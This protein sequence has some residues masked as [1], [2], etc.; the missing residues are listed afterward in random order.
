M[1]KVSTLYCII[2]F[3]ALF[4][5]HSVCQ[6]KIHRNLDVEDGLVQSQVF[7]ILEAQDGYLWVGTADGLSRW[8]GVNFV[9]F[10]ADD[11]VIGDPFYAIHESSD[12]TLYFGRRNGVS[13]YKNG[14]LAALDVD[15]FSEYTITAITESEDG[16]LYF[17]TG[18]YGVIE[19]KNGQNTVLNEQ[20]GLAHNQ[21]NSLHI[22]KDGRLYLGTAGGL[23][24]YSERK[25]TNVS[26]EK[27]LGSNL[28]LSVF[29]GRNEKSYIA[30]LQGLGVYHNNSLEKV[31]AFGNSGLG[32]INTVYEATDGTLYAGTG[33]SGVECVREGKFETITDEHGLGDNWITCIYE[34]KDGTI[35]FG[36]R[37]GLSIYQNGKFET[38]NRDGLTQNSVQTIY[39]DHSARMYFSGFADG[40]TIY[41]DGKYE[42]LTQRDG[43]AHDWVVSMSEGKDKTMYFGTD[44]SGVSVY[45][46]GKFNTLNQGNGLPRN[47]VSSMFTGSD[48]TIYF[49]FWNG[50]VGIY[51]EGEFVQVW[52]E[53]SGLPGSNI[54]AFHESQSETL[55]IGTRGNGV[56]LYRDGRQEKAIST[57]NGLASNIVYAIHEAKDGTFYFGTHRGLSILKAGQFKTFSMLNGLTSN[58]IY[59][60]LEGDSSQIYLVTDVGINIVDFSSESPFVRTLRYR[61]GLASDECKEKLYL[62]DSKGNFWFGTVK[63]ITKYDPARDLPN[64][65][66]PKLHLSRVSLLGQDVLAADKSVFEHDQ[67]Y[68]KYD[69]IGINLSAPEKVVYRYRLSGV[70]E[71]WVETAQRSVQ[72]T[73]LDDGSY[74]F[75]VKARNEWGVWSEPE[76][77]NFEILPP[78]WER[79]WF[80][81][82]AGLLFFGTIAY[83][84]M[85]HVRQ[86]L[87]TE[88]L[89]TKIAADLHDSIGSGLAEITILSEICIKSLAQNARRQAEQ[90]L[91]TIGK[92]S[93]SLVT[94]MS[95]I[96]W[97]V[98]PQ[99]DSLY[100]LL[101]R[102]KG[103]YE[104]LLRHKGIV[105]KMPNVKSMEKIHLPMEHRHQLYLLF[106][107]GVTNCLKHSDCTELILDTEVSSRELKMALK[108]NGKGFDV[109]QILSKKN[110]GE[111][112]VNMRRRAE[113]M[114]GALHLQSSLGKG[115]KVEFKGSMSQI[116]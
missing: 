3:N 85:S 84:V 115:T 76:S 5:T 15:E 40:V 55:Y 67:N 51:K 16:T 29:E 63:G 62:K 19:R 94:S 113:S 91:E 42:K 69:F 46:N 111:G 4:S 10:Q 80:L 65:M 100:D 110:T 56:Y 18:S 66:A 104:D 28:V 70:D 96:V 12:G 39:E 103:S 107:E 82:L 11:D 49:G 26:V 33:G 14:K 79:I 72:Y 88:R 35:Y 77:Y 53:E 92:I 20:D 116:F 108:D 54:Y 13:V 64:L 73:S 2:L 58:K 36:T 86:L 25:F 27:T 83:F 87:A 102:L 41:T 60:I 50:G 89:R 90:R 74:T 59:G 52:N 9:N 109:N 44:F 30:T 38:L 106:K 22:G 68:L 71:D 7:S 34:A 105:F 114:G 81:T 21:V 78:F 99:Q 93:R 61:D 8:D 101:L 75:D 48:G 31:P 112:L 23:S 43:L 47:Q 6:I 45:K 24:I 17:G 57:K 37:V 98:S 1:N 95:D 32:R 97:L